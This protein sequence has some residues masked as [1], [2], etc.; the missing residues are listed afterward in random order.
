MRLQRLGAY[1]LSVCKC[2]W[3]AVSG[4]RRQAFSLGRRC[5]ADARRMRGASRNG[6]VAKT[7]MLTKRP[8]YPLAPSGRELSRACRVTEG[9]RA[10]HRVGILN[11]SCN[12]QKRSAV[13]AFPSAIGKNEGTARGVRGHLRFAE[14]GVAERRRM[15]C[16]GSRL[17]AVNNCHCKLTVGSFLFQYQLPT[18]HC[19]LTTLTSSEQLIVKIIRISDPTAATEETSR[20][21]LLLGEKVAANAAG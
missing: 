2:Q 15:R 5:R 10:N 17:T 20:P 13:I 16:H 1:T 9:E 18:D 11:R 21:C 4:D 14:P 19:P 8:S 7:T 12:P 3:L 6:A